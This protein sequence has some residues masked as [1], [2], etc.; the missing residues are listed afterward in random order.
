MEAIQLRKRLPGETAGMSMSDR[1]KECIALLSCG[2]Q[3]TAIARDLN[4]SVKTVSTYLTRAR[5]KLSANN[6]THLAVLW[7]R[8]Q[9]E[10]D[11]F[12][13]AFMR[14]LAPTPEAERVTYNVVK[15]EKP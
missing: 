7:A 13:S 11:N 3:P 12:I 9:W 14:P 5:D 4:L 8:Q 2:R 10:K 1:E 15:W 6:N